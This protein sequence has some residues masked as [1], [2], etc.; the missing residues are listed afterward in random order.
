MSGLVQRA[1]NAGKQISANPQV[2]GVIEQVAGATDRASTFVSQRYSDV[3]REN[4]KYVIG[5]TPSFYVT[6]DN[7]WKHAFYTTLAECAL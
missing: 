1:V 2:K 3:V 4:S 5:S 7:V 6:R